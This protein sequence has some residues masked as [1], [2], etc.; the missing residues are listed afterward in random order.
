M[1]K[2]GHKFEGKWRCAYMRFKRDK[3]EG[4]NVVTNLKN[5]ER[6]NK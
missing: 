6:K 5:K 4:T 3:R 2:R 1:K